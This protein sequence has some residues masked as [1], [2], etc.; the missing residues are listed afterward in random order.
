MTRG[1]FIVLEGPEGSGK[2][3]QIERLSAR[4]VAEGLAPTVVR[5]PGGTRIGEAVRIVLLDAGNSRMTVGTEL[6]LYMACRAQ[7]VHEVIDPALDAGRAVLADRF[8][9]STI[10]YQGIAGGMGSEGVKKLYRE[11]CGETQPDLVVVLD[12]DAEAGLGRVT[13]EFDR[14]ERKPLEFHR[15]VREGYLAV[16]GNDPDRYVVLDASRT[17]DEVAEAVWREVKRRVLS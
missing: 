12:V 10:V 4:L 3:T 14:M 6:L 17:V 13:K 15:R 16:A 9:T 1:K 8:L 2:T 5:E 11:T 7:L